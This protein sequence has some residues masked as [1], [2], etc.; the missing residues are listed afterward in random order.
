MLW[1]P[2]FAYFSECQLKFSLELV[3]WN[4]VI[5]S[6]PFL[7]EG[8]WGDSPSVLA[9]V[10]SQ[11]QSFAVRSVPGYSS[12]FTHEKGCRAAAPITL[13][14]WALFSLWWLVVDYCKPTQ[15][16]TSC[17]TAANPV[18]VPLTVVMC[19]LIRNSFLYP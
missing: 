12:A 2:P 14:P 9:E 8:L 10:V 17:S 7:I 11:K 1:D 19:L 5:L 3:T 18:V 4:R 16:A 13:L 15:M 6:V